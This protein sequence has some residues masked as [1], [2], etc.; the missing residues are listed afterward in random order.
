MRCI[1]TVCAAFNPSKRI[2]RTAA[3][4]S[5]GTRG[6]TAGGVPCYGPQRSYNHTASNLSGRNLVMGTSGR[7]LFLSQ[8]LLVH[9][10]RRCAAAICI[11]PIAV[12]HA[13]LVHERPT[14]CDGMPPRQQEQ[15]APFLEADT[16]GPTRPCSQLLL[17]PN[18][19]QLSTV[20]PLLPLVAP[21]WHLK[22]LQVQPSL[23]GLYLTKIRIDPR[24]WRR[25]FFYLL[26]SVAG[27][28]DR[29]PGAHRGV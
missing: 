28:C 17:A 13:R 21:V 29:R 6:C 4:S 23:R 11:D 9:A 10:C 2:S 5:Q 7:D 1:V 3:T 20:Y 12:V 14:T 19:S 24:R 22:P 15:H 18:S 25:H 16:R 27:Q 8:V 26:P